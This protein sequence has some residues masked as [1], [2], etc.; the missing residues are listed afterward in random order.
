M[1]PAL[2]PPSKG[3]CPI[4]NDDQTFAR[5]YD[6]PEDYT[7]KVNTNF[8]FA[9]FFPPSFGPS[10]LSQHCPAKNM[11]TNH[12]PSSLIDTDYNRIRFTMVY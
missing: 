11:M 9:E 3:C 2:C 1:I 10:F 5:Q 8:L 7:L 12:N 4:D 6:T